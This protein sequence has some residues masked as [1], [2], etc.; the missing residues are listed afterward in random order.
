MSNGS[1]RKTNIKSKRAS[2]SID[3]LK[4]DRNVKGLIKVLCCEK[5]EYTH[6]RAAFALDQI[7]DTRDIEPL[8]VVLK[9]KDKDINIREFVLSLL[10]KIGKPSVEPLITLL[11]ND[12]ISM[13]Q[14][15]ARALRQIEEAESKSERVYTCPTCEKEFLVEATQ[16]GLE[17]FIRKHAGQCKRETQ[18]DTDVP[19][20]MYGRNTFFDG[21]KVKP[22]FG[23]RK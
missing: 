7:V 6:K 13:K 20:Q 8:I 22:F 14:A 9:D 18:F 1:K 11:Q 5:E 10:V 21:E 23:Y 19:L 16:E 15:V 2:D 12:D 3:R 17:T 4:T